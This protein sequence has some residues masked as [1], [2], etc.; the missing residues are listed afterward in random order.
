MTFLRGGGLRG[1][2]GARLLCVCEPAL[3]LKVAAV[4][5]V[6]LAYSVSVSLR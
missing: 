1:I 3:K 2:G 4:E 5:S 6:L